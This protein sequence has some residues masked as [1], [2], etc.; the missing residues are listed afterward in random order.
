M[1][2][3][4]LSAEC[5]PVA[6]SGGLGDVVGALPKYQ[7]QAGHYAKVV[8]PFY[9]NK[10]TASQELRIDFE[11]TI[12][13][14]GRSHQFHVLK[15]PHNTLGFDLYLVRVNGLLDRENIYAYNDDNERFLAFQ[16]ATL[17]WLNQWQ[18]QPDIIHCHDHHTGLVPFLMRYGLP[19]NAL[20]KV[21]TV[22]TIHNGNYQGWAAWSMSRAMPLFD[23]WR[24]GLLDWGGLINPL[25]SAVRCADAVTTVSPSYMNELM[26]KSI[27]LESLFQQERA[28]CVGIL[29]GID[30]ETWNP[31]TDPLLPIHYSINDFETGKYE[32]KKKIGELFNLNPDL[33]LTI[34]I[35][36]LVG[37]KAA[38]ILVA[39]LRA[40]VHSTLGKMNFIVLGSG[41]SRVEYDL[42]ELKRDL[43]HV[44]NCYIGYHEGLSHQLYAAADFLLMPSRVEPCGLNQMYALRYG[45][46]PMVRATGGLKDTVI[47][48]GDG[49]WGLRFL[50]ATPSDIAHACHRALNIFNDEDLFAKL[51]Q[52]MML[53][54][55][56]WER[57][58][59]DYLEKY[60]EI[61]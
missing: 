54:D 4:H 30:V 33:P 53:L 12:S 61:L 41:D 14:D 5:Y 59:T 47:D 16:V 51:R 46:M 3:I 27:G 57:S 13:L 50:H 44:Y 19:F 31:E 55:N 22:F 18:H 39:A 49:G 2:I 43:G 36:R 25:A 52:R 37:E 26:Y 1:E 17:T 60:R 15:E 42:T 23:D 28:K 29:N 9:R 40:S 21:K 38:D 35:G 58:A 8:M 20:R 7:T 10:W 45:T 11:G 32:N 48:I 24:A 56:S 6:K 34:F